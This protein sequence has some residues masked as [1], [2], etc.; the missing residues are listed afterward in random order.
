MT[1]IDP[2]RLPYGRPEINPAPA[3]I[4]LA[5]RQVRCYVK[6]CEKVLK[7]PT[8]RSRG[9]VCPIHGIRCHISNKAA[10]YSYA[11]VRRNIVAAQELF[12]E[13]LRGHPFKFESH[14]FGYENSEDAVSW[15]VFRLLQ[16]A[17]MLRRVAELIT[18]FP[19]PDEPDLYLW[20]LRCS[21]DSLEPW[22]LLI[23][24]RHRF[25]SSL[26][27][28]RPLTEPDIALHLPGRYLILI[29][30]KFTSVNMCYKAG[31]RRNPSSLTLAELLDIYHEPAL[32]ILDFEQARCSSRIY[33][34]LWRNTIFAEWMAR[35]D[36]VSTAAYHANLVRRRSESESAAA[37][38]QLVR[39]GYQDR[40]RRITWEDIHGVIRDAPEANLAREYL[41]NKTAGLRS[42][43]D[44]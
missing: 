5:P 3:V 17:R 25:E 11:D 19:S 21:D 15:N 13:R 40:F 36:H 16:E 32:E 34:Q 7:A 2:C 38:H 14:R 31:P 1:S 33:Y 39:G 44:L 18:G 22:D 41:E 4:C 29:E 23:R 42:A 27:V 8:R 30:A 20:G 35:A 28:D 26:P 43:F 37:F 12:A 24:A 9:D 6:G 10:T